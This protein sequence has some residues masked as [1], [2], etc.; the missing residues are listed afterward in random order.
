MIPSQR[1]PRAFFSPDVATMSITPLMAERL[2]EIVPD[3]FECGVVGKK[4]ILAGQAQPDKPACHGSKGWP[5]REEPRVKIEEAPQA[6][7]CFDKTQYS[8]TEVTSAAVAV[9][10][11]VAVLRSCSCMRRRRRMS[12]V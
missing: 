4:R 2:Y 11:A 12:A 10:V 8:I 3:H 6:A 7:G 9:A 1:P 5:W